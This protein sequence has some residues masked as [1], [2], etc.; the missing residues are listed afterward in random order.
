MS[1]AMEAT[2]DSAPASRGQAPRVSGSGRVCSLFVAPAPGAPMRAVLSVIAVAGRGL[3][4]DRYF[5]EG[6]TSNRVDRM[7]EV[8]LVELEVLEELRCEHDLIVHPQDTRRNII[9]QGLS[10]NALIGCDFRVGPTVLR[11]IS[12][13]EPC[14][15]LERV[16]RPGVLRALVHRAGLRAR[17]VQGGTIRVGDLIGECPA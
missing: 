5:R 14:A 6:G 17:I 3:R 7:T 2:T 4:G 8:T 10:L 13:C 15:H 9:T 12:A 16:T 11:G 1:R